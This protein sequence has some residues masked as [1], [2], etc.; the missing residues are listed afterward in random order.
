LAAA[1][2]AA[3]FVPGASI[4]AAEHDAQTFTVNCSRGQTIAR[5]LELGDARK[6]LVLVV[7]GMCKENVVIS[8]DRVTLQGNP[9]KVATVQAV[10]PK[11]A[12]IEVRATWVSIEGLTVTGGLS[13]ILAVGVS[14]LEVT[15][16]V[17][18]NAA[19][20]GISLGASFGWLEGNKIQNNGRNGLL[21]TAAQAYVATSEIAM[22]AESG[23]R[24]NSNSTLLVSDTTISANGVYGIRLTG[25]SDAQISGGT[26]SGNGTNSATSVWF[27]GGASIESS[28]A[29]FNNAGIS[30]NLG[31]GLIVNNG[32]SINSFNTAVSANAAEGVIFYVGAIGNI[33]GGTISN[34][35]GNGLWLGVNSTAQVGNVSIMNNAQ[36]GIALSQ[37]SKLYDF[38]TPL[39]VSGNAG[40]GLYCYDSESSAADLSNITFSAN[41]A[42]S[43]SCT[44]Y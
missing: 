29:E 35:G 22:N 6:P 42:G 11:A 9:P 5:A 4:A 14:A 3:F 26:I 39:T 41:G 18:Q 2:A 15:N 28:T 30:S 34:N 12:V 21:L 24:L 27:K 10:N 20:N 16:S 32:G 23:I 43:A 31:R 1:L 17:I 7:R 33:N 19:L 38:A 13:G 8:R 36:H 44:G 40:W 25:G 37:A